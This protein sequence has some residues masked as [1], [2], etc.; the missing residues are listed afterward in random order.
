MR[1][2]RWADRISLGFIA[3]TITFWS[4]PAKAI[5]AFARKY[6]TSCTTCHTAFPKLNPFGEAFR[7]NN[8]RFPGDDWTRSRRR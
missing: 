8:Y 2:H 5:P 7:R 1:S 4:V 3:L 6:Q